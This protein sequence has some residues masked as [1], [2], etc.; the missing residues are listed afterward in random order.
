MPG[1]SKNAICLLQHLGHI[2]EKIPHESLGQWN[3]YPGTPLEDTPQKNEVP[4]ESPEKM[5]VKMRIPGGF[6]PPKQGLLGRP[7][8][9]VDGL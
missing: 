8:K 1:K 4:K 5:V 6:N 7:S 3:W 9:L 2:L